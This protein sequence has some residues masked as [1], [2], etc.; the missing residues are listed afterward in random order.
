MDKQNHRV[1]PATAPQPQAVIVWSRV[2]A[3]A[4]LTV[5][6]LL[7]LALGI[8]LAWGVGTNGARIIE[9]WSAHPVQS[10]ADCHAG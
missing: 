5:S 2:I 1:K 4:A 8:P 6:V 10:N 3:A 7:I 9:M